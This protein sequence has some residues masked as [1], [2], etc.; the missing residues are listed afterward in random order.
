ML[1]EPSLGLAPIVTKAVYRA[2]GEIGSE[3]SLLIVE[4]NAPVALNVCSRAYVLMSGKCVLSASAA[5]LTDRQALLDSYLGH[6]VEEEPVV[7]G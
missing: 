7:G 1:D 4:Q 2:L 3:V 6:G 5:E